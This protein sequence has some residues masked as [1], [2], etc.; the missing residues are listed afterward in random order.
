MMTGHKRVLMLGA[1]A[2]G[3]IGAL[4]LASTR[5]D[6]VFFPHDYQ[7]LD[8]VSVGMHEREV[9]ERLGSTEP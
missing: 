5:L 6:R 4:Y 9:K 2:V 7:R 3:L 1:L 8:L